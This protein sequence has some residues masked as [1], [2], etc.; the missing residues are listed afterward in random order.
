MGVS[1]CGRFGVGACR[2]ITERVAPR[3]D[4]TY[5]THATYQS[6]HITPMSLI[7]PIRP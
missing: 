1:A 5:A 6:G 7:G 4:G 2:R 3:S